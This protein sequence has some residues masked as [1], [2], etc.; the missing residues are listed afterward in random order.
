VLDST[1]R[2]Y[3]PVLQKITFVVHVPCLRGNS[4][5]KRFPTAL[6]R[7]LANLSDASESAQNPS[8]NKSA[9]DHSKGASFSC[10]VQAGF[11]CFEKN[12]DLFSSYCRKFDLCF[13]KSM[14]ITLQV[15][16]GGRRVSVCSAALSLKQLEK[17]S[18]RRT[19]AAR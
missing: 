4:N 15:C 3:S 18:T 14:P 9:R 5:T 12:S 2:L 6:L 17:D 10:E 7:C 8:P 1:R 11:G 19:L 13:L 16:L